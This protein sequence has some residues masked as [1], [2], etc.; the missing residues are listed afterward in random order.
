[1]KTKK[2][3]TKKQQ[4]LAF[5]SDLF[6]KEPLGSERAKIVDIRGNESGLDHLEI[7]TGNQN[8]IWRWRVYCEEC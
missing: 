3:Q 6:L 4:D 8:S 5:L 7:T 2:K 1:M